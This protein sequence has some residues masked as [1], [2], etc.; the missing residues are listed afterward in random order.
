[1][2]NELRGTGVALATPL[3][4]DYS[5]D[6]VSLKKLLDHIVEGN[7]DYLVVL[8]TTGESPVFTWREKLTILDYVFDHIGSKKPIVFGLGGNNTFDLIEKSKELAAFE[9]S[10]ILSVAPY[11]SRPSQEGILQ[12]FQMLG[13]AF[14]HPIVLYNVPARTSCN[15]EADTTLKLASHENIIAM[16][17]ASGDLV[18]CKRIADNRPE[19]FML[20]SGDDSLSLDIIQMG[21]EGIISV[22]GN[23]LPLEF[24]TMVNA[25]LDGNMEYASRLNDQLKPVYSLLM[26]EGNPSSLKVGL[27]AL[28]I[29]KR[30]VKPPL[31]NGSDNLLSEWK[32]HLSQLVELTS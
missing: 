16:K 6:Y 24:T 26:Q 30:T 20:L 12:H 19:G 25:A 1:M 14:P 15:M 5:V 3:N 4:D 17:E 7:A 18:Q 21:G 23:I 9:L 8:G 10:A 29:C 13:D 31:Y 2:M 32:V 22:V 27:E 11:Y 28:D